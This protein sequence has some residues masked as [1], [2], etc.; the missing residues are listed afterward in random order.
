MS[1]VEKETTTTGRAH[2]NRVKAKLKFPSAGFLT[3]ELETSPRI[4]NPSTATSRGKTSKLRVQVVS[5]D[6]CC[7]P[8][9]LDVS[10]IPKSVTCS[11]R[12]TA[13][14]TVGKVMGQ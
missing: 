12:D 7:Y 14:S 8:K 3:E 2:Q 10:D 13:S 4:L 1:R 5:W 6:N 11:S 9:L